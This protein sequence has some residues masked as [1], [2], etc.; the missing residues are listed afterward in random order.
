MNSIET[1]LQRWLDYYRANVKTFE[2]EETNYTATFVKGRNRQKF[3][4]SE[5][6]AKT[7]I[8]GAMIL[9]DIKNFEKL[10]GRPEMIKPDYFSIRNKIPPFKAEKIYN[11]DINAAYPNAAKKLGFISEKTFNYLMTIKKQ[12]R[13]AALGMLAS[14]KTITYYF[15]GEISDIEIKEKETAPF[16]YLISNEIDTVMN[17]LINNL[18]SFVFYWF[19]GIYFIDSFEINKAV[20]ELEFK[21]YPYKIEAL[22]NFEL[23]RKSFNILMTFEKDGKKKSF[24]IPDRHMINRLK[25]LNK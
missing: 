25:L 6:P 20:K 16:F 15:D 3:I 19:D 24:E 21:G 23:K 18:H 14:K 4:T 7:F 11:V 8:A 1:N 10:H 9:K 5:M 2:V 13:L 17:C 22:K 12:N